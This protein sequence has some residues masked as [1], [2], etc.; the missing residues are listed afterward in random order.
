MRAVTLVPIAAPD[1]VQQAYS[2]KT[3]RTRV[4]QL[5]WSLG[6]LGAILIGQAN[7]FSDAYLGNGRLFSLPALFLSIVVLVLGLRVNPRPRLGWPFGLLIVA[8]TYSIMVGVVVSAPK[9]PIAALVEEA[10]KLCRSM[11]M[12]L[13]AF[14]GFQAL[15]Q[16]GR[17]GPLANLF[18][19]IALPV[20][21]YQVLAYLMGHQ[22]TIKP[23][24]AYEYQFRYSGVFGDPNPAAGFSV[25]LVCISLLS[26]FPNWARVCLTWLALAGVLVTF[27]RGGLIAFISVVTVNGLLGSR[28]SRLGSLS[29]ALFGAW[30]VLMGIPWLSSSG[31]LPSQAGRHLLV[32][33]ELATGQGGLEDNS[34]GRLLTESLAV[35]GESPWVGYGYAGYR[36]ILGMGSHNMFTSFALLAGALATVLYVA[37][38]ASLCYAGFRRLCARAGSFVISIAVWTIVMGFSIHSILHDKHSV[39]LL[40]LACAVSVT[41]LPTQRRAVRNSADTRPIQSRSEL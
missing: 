3:E 36:S 1:P 32:L 27:S 11:F 8:M 15:D 26:T 41:R 35:I 16:R 23:P 28:G 40:T 12:M 19:L 22:P 30:F 39:L 17:I 34:R 4:R 2:L 13:C 5:T 9:M 20:V 25:L 33:H 10:S 14:I 37:A 38:L 24:E 7:E 21:S 29:L 18:T 31:M 6:L